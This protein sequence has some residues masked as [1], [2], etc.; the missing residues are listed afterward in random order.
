MSCYY[1]LIL[2]CT[3]GPSAIVH[4]TLHNPIAV[5]EGVLHDDVLYTAYKIIHDTAGSPTQ[6]NRT[7]VHCYKV[8]QE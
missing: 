8:V 1:T 6:A 4:K 5:G 3:A 2:H 7:K